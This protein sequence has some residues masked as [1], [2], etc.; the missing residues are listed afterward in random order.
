MTSFLSAKR[1][2][3]T[4][5]AGFLGRAVCERVSEH[6]VADLFVPR[7]RQFDLTDGEA[8]KRMFDAARPFGGRR[9]A[10]SGTFRP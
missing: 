9:S 7:S 8:V 6:G 4:G 10:A 2:C 5:G 1:V 3:V